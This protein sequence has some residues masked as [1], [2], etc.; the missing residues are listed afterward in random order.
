MSEGR[1]GGR[2]EQGWAVCGPNRVK[3][4]YRQEPNRA[5]WQ[6]RRVPKQGTRCSNWVY[7]AQKE[8]LGLIAGHMEGDKHER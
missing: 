7:E 3:E 1:S 4:Q 2:R 5:S 6:G 8:I